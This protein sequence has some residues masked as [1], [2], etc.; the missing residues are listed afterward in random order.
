M[1]KQNLSGGILIV[2]NIDNIPIILLGKSNIPKRIGQY[3]SFGGKV[4]AE[5][6]TSLHTAIRELIEEFFNVKVPTDIINMIAIKIRE[7][8]LILKQKEFFGM[9]Y[10]INFKGLNEIYINITECDN[11]L[12]KYNNDNNFDVIKYINERVITEKSDNGLNEI[13]SIEIIKISDIKENKIKLRWYT[14]K[15]IS[16]MIK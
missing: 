1:D 15:I 16:K 10:M 7:K 3:E 8:K 13:Q 12:N 5:D 11:M 4:E 2:D 14:D 6:I 9:S